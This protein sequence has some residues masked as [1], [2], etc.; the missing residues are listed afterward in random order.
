MVMRN[1]DESVK[2]NHN[3]NWPHISDHSISISIIFGSESD[4]TN[5]LLNLI[6]AII[7]KIYL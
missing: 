7:D 5:V 6:R 3:Q 2:T 4:R 1:Y